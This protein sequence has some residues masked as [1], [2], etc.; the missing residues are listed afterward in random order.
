MLP[1]IK[2]P[3]QEFELHTGKDEIHQTFLEK[4][5]VSSKH[6]VGKIRGNFFAYRKGKQFKDEREEKRKEVSNIFDAERYKKPDGYVVR[7]YVLRGLQLITKKGKAKS[8]DSYVSLKVS[9]E[10]QKTDIVDKTQNPKFY[11]AFDFKTRFPDVETQLTVSVFNDSGLFGDDLI[12]ETSISLENRLYSKQWQEGRRPT[13]RRPLFTGKKGRLP[14]GYIE[15]CI[16]I[17]HESEAGKRPLD[18]L[19]NP[20]T[21]IP[22]ELR[23]VL[24]NTKNVT[25][26]K[27]YKKE[28]DCCCYDLCAPP[29]QSDIRLACG[30]CGAKEKPSTT[31]T[32]LRSVDGEGMFNWRTKHIIELPA[33]EP[34]C[35][36]KVQVWNVNWSPDDCIAEAVIPLWGWFEHARR[37]YEKIK[38][39]KDQMDK[40]VANL[41]RQW[42][43]MTHPQNSDKGDVEIS[44]ELI[45]KDIA[46]KPRYKAAVGKDGWDFAKNAPD[47][48]IPPHKRPATSFPWYRLDLQILYRVKYCC[49]RSRKAIIISALT[50]VTGF[51]GY[52]LAKQYVFTG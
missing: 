51:V 31:D 2:D 40:W 19:L 24:W 7:V 10:A 18:Y 33:P 34:L 46:D 4:L 52:E 20:P 13:E 48:R 50:S 28:G 23:V 9:G 45:P 36:F 47:R 49:K 30:L 17:V 5:F 27:I 42:V 41:P 3:F 6:A 38:T 14:Q 22:W 11:K 29:N 16:D 35:N 1:L 15:L 26:K 21:R 39:D 25:P 37:N 32:H 12:G 8:C 43:K 44:M